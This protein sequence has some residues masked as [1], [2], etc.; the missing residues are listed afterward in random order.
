MLST[1]ERQATDRRTV[2]EVRTIVNETLTPVD[3]S[4]KQRCPNTVL[5]NY[6][7][8]RLDNQ[9]RGDSISTETIQLMLRRL[10]SHRG[11]PL[12]KRRLR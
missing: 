11:N 6:Q 4:L 10:R 7:E 1:G 3:Q 2:Q 9:C 12:V 5:V 8:L